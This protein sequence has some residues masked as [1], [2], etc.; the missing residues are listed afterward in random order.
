MMKNIYHSFLPSTKYKRFCSLL[1]CATIV[2]G[3]LQATVTTNTSPLYNTEI[4]VPAPIKATGRV[5][6]EMGE[7]L[8]G[9]TI[10]IQGTPRG[11]TTDVDGT[12]SIDVEVGAKLMISYIGMEDQ[13]ITVKNSK[14]LTITMA[15]KVDELDEVT[16][17]AFAKQKKESVLASV[18]TVKPAELK[19]PASNL[20]AALS[21]R[22]AGLISYQR[23]GEPG[24]DN[25]DF[26][27]RGVTT[28]GY[29]T[30]PLILIDGVEM[31]SS[32]LSRLQ[33]DDIASFSIM[34]DATATA[35]YGSRGANGVILVN[36]KGGT[37]G[38]AKISARVVVTHSSPTK[39]A[40]WADPITY[41]NMHNEASLY[42]GNGLMHSQ[43]KIANT[44]A[45]LNPNVFPAVDWYDELFK[46]SNVNYSANMNVQGGTNI[47]KYYIA[48]TYSSDSGNLKSAK[49][50]NFN[51]NIKLNRYLLR[52]N[53]DVNVSKTT[54]AT[55][56]L[57]G[58][59]DDYSGPI[60]TGKEIYKMITQTSPVLY[61]PYYKPDKINETTP[62]LL[63]GNYDTG[64][65]LNPYAEMTRGYR[66]T[67]T[68]LMMAQ[69]ELNQDLKF[70]T[71]GLKARFM[72]NTNRRSDYTVQ[73]KYDPFYFSMGSYDALSDTYIL[74]ALNPED[75]TDFLS[76]NV[77][78]KEVEVNTYLEAAVNYDRTFKD[79]HA[80]SGLMVFTMNNKLESKGVSS[81]ANTDNIQKS[82]PKRN[83]SLS[84]R[85]TYA[86][87]DR[88]FIEAN[89]GYNGSE[90]FADKERWGFF[91][92][93]G[94]GYLMSNERFWNADLKKVIS[95]L[96]FKATYGLVG[97]DAIGDSGDRFY[98]LSVVN[99][100]DSGMGY[101]WG[102][103]NDRHSAN[104]VSISRY[105]NPNVTWEISKKTN[106]GVELG[107]FDK[108]ELQ[109]D[110]FR[111]DR[112]KILMERANLPSSLGLEAKP[113]SNVGEARSQ[114]IDL[115]LDYNQSIN[116]DLW[117]SGRLNFTYGRGKYKVYEEPDYSSTPWRSRIGQSVKQAWGYVAERL[118][119]DEADIANSPKQTFG[120]YKPGDIKYKDING[121]GQ[122]TNADQVP[123]GY[124][125]SPEIN[126]GFGYSMGWKGF[127]F[128]FFFNG[129]ARESFW[130][131]YNAITPFY[132]SGG[133]NGTVAVNQLLTVI[134]D[135]H[136]SVNNRD[137]YAFWPRL[138]TAENK[139]NSQR[140]TWFMRDGSFLR[141]KQIDFGY[142]LPKKFLK[143]IGFS[144]IRIY[145]SGIN[146]LCFS[147][148][149][150]WDPELAGNGFNYP[151][152]R[153][154]SVGINFSL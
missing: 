79:K 14:P 33:V 30:D 48:G 126:Y 134:S 95:K 52:A 74:S 146:L 104:G 28:F 64:N 109:V 113:K 39:T 122:I 16:I 77:S 96:K 101:T 149:K 23:S 35:L 81:S 42:D 148:F 108:L 110:I 123:I 83:M 137:P 26:F 66:D 118:F 132:N 80:V 121:D 72:F 21:G 27:V 70:I 73:R 29:K 22:V 112:S 111:D 8:P 120:D 36:T 41:M 87:D 103:L 55:V 18:S 24:A 115:S 6:D 69:V 147:K 63:Y 51:N 34:K 129:L 128:S 106:I 94:V 25:A 61:P 82:L 98:Y 140:S 12:F 19:T 20:T 116:K 2:Q 105:A 46:K 89:F 136:W 131:D 143:K 5:I 43:Q 58:T 139:N 17:V 56:R 90:R 133:A 114:G 9:V 4:N 130:L 13:I 49:Q 86:Y 154:H 1:I 7:P 93:A 50:N 102:S 119:I 100:K 53:V 32:D 91:P 142:T 3:T 71:K 141:L 60:Y 92:S 99:L 153:T 68:S 67:S 97:N 65:Y 59:M 57:H 44:M 38:P 54:K 15:Q 11:V 127:D 37:E 84:G 138:S 40:E 45:G 152:Q 78:T 88:Y 10:V 107:L 124:P 31:T 117:M 76:P 85:F 144:S 145:Y 125:T 75:G 151:L 62:Y 135:D 47:A 150:L